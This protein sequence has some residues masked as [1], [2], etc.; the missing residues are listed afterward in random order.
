[1]SLEAQALTESRF[2][3]TYLTHPEKSHSLHAIAEIVERFGSIPEEIFGASPP[4]KMDPLYQW[5]LLVGLSCEIS[6]F[7]Q[8]DHNPNDPGAYIEMANYDASLD[9]WFNELPSPLKWTP[10]NILLSSKSFFL[11]Q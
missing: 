9:K 3:S 2:W 11:L 5:T 10:D 8:L 4:P 6:L 7:R 1:M